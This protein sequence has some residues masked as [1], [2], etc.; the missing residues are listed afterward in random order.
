[1]AVMTV[2]GSAALSALAAGV[3][4][5]TGVARA[6]LAAG[7]A[8]D[9]A[10]EVFHL[11]VRPAGEHTANDGP[12]ANFDEIDDLIGWTAAPPV[13]PDGLPVGAPGN[14]SGTAG[15]SDGDLDQL[16][17]FRR[18][19]TVER[20]K[21]DGTAGAAVWVVTPDDTPHRRVTVRALFET[22]RDGVTS[23]RPLAERTAILSR[24]GAG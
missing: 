24:G 10:D 5:A 7:L 8:D 20:V 6:A 9:L 19:V 22:E 3:S 16:S 17:R 21:N 18:T 14:I 15:D 13:G 1:M 23:V 11:P 2:A 12:R 4:A